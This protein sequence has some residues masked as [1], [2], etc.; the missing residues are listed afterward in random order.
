[1]KRHLIFFLAA[2]A[3]C[4]CCP[5]RAL[6]E[7][8]HEDLERIRGAAEAYAL[9]VAATLAPASAAVEVTA[10]HLDSRLRLPA[11]TGALDAFRTTG[12]TGMP[13]SVGVRCTGITP[14]SI[15]VPIKVEV[16]VDVVV[17]TAPGLR[18]S[19]VRPEQLS[20]EPRDVASMIRGYYTEIADAE[21]MVLRRQAPPGTVLDPTL[22]E[23]ELVVRRGQQVKLE[24]GSGPVAVSIQGEALADAA[25]GQRVRV[26]NTASQVVV[27]GLVTDSGQ[28][29][30]SP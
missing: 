21:G 10:S 20:L 27:E 16:I 23:P 30:V 9:D 13:S 14:W 22:L 12:Q 24:A 28:V 1:M 17:L 8:V 7:N 6:A 3:P 4:L 25:R 15:H 11:C 18:G 29:V 5:V 26:R 19:P 2:L